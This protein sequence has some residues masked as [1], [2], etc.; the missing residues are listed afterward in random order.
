MVS[1]L[2]FFLALFVIFMMTSVSDY[3]SQESSS[4]VTVEN[5]STACKLDNGDH[6]ICK[7]STRR[8]TSKEVI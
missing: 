2:I 3:Q 7:T 1:S 5:I 8:E 6:Q 4:V